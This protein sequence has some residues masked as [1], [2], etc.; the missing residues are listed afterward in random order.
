[1]KDDDQRTP[2][3]TRQ[4]PLSPRASQ[5]SQKLTVTSPKSSR[6]HSLH[7]SKAEP[8]QVAKAAK[9]P[10]SRLSQSNTH[11]KQTDGSKSKSDPPR[12]RFNKSSSTSSLLKKDDSSKNSCS[13]SRTTSIYN[14]ESKKELSKPEK[15]LSA[16]RKMLYAS[17]PNLATCLEESDEEQG[18]NLTSC[19][20]LS[21][22]SPNINGLD[23]KIRGKK[24]ESKSSRDSTSSLAR[25]RSSS[26][27]GSS[28]LKEF[29]QKSTGLSLP[30]DSSDKPPGTKTRGSW[31]R[32]TDNDSK[33]LMPPPLSAA[34][35]KTNKHDSF[36]K[37]AVHS[38]RRSTSD[39]TLD[40]A[41]DILMGRSGILGPSS[42][43][44]ME[45]SRS[46]SSLNDP[47]VF[48][49]T[50]T[51]PLNSTFPSEI[52]SCENSTDRNNMSLDVD[53]SFFSVATEIENVAA[54]MRCQNLSVKNDSHSQSICLSELDASPNDLPEKDMPSSAASMIR[55]SS[56][57]QNPPVLNLSRNDNKPNDDNSKSKHKSQDLHTAIFTS[58]SDSTDSDNTGHHSVPALPSS[59]APTLTQMPQAKDYLVKDIVIIERSNK[60]K[61]SLTDD[62]NTKKTMS[63]SKTPTNLNIAD[64]KTK[65]KRS[66]DV[67][68]NRSRTSRSKT[69]TNFLTLDALD[70]SSTSSRV[71]VVSERRGSS[72]RSKTPTSFSSPPQPVPLVDEGEEVASSPSVRERIATLRKNL[73]TRSSSPGPM[74]PRST[75]RAQSPGRSS[76]QSN[77]SLSS[78]HTSIDTAVGDHPQRPTARSR[79]SSPANFLDDTIGFDSHADIDRRISAITCDGDRR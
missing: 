13:A 61:N 36:V 40:Q 33:Q 73:E 24:G 39:L 25:R 71:S 60:Q 32:M 31:N 30:P 69:P 26:T 54:E 66:S 23:K 63:R 1:M 42:A 2:T 6:P 64:S 77:L 72:S 21:K 70:E 46:S 48:S 20:D 16:Q 4:T 76:M 7:L 28:Q 68:E 3:G 78:S 62:K 67:S 58:I 65:S 9:P 45:K 10:S 34:V 15:K 27:S 59:P 17:V 57:S 44:S 12:N 37:K 29:K 79:S 51:F 35:A 52:N 22:S 50:D 49:M 53:P 41:K 47:L 18:T 11:K 74:S 38:K 55:S 19:V 56:R 5:T 14:L 43:S 75:G 8:D